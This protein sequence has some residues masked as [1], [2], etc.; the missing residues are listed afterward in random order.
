[1]EPLSYTN[2]PIGL[3]FVIAGYGYLWGDVLVDPS[4]PVKDVDAKID[5]AILTYARVLDFWGQS[6][7]FALIVPYAWL[8][9]TGEVFGQSRTVDRNGLTDISMRL[10]INLLGAPALS[11][12]EFRG[13]QQDTI[14]G[15][16]VLVTAP[17]GKYDSG[18]LIN[19]GTNRW[20]FRP[21]IGVSKAIGRWIFEV[22]L[23]V[24]FFTDNDDFLLGNVRSQDPLYGLQGHVIYSFNPSRWAS[25]DATY[26]TGGQTSVNGKPDN[27]QQ[28]NSRWGASFS[29]AFDRNNSVKLYFTS[30]LAARFGSNFSAAGIAW[31]YRWGAGL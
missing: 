9:A 27:D 15:V 28:N 20:S 10:S 16:S 29:Q 8:T 17:T 5:T 13:Y 7:T 31:Q 18:R 12:Q 6:G 11:L 23:G 25:L 3:N 24:T 2:A 1:M 30:G 4:L 19:I 22:A 26:Y 14:V 21:E